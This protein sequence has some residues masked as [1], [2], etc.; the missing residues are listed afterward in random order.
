MAKWIILIGAV[1]ALGLLSLDA[2]AVTPVAPMADG[3]AVKV[4]G[5]VV[6][7]DGKNAGAGVD[8]RLVRLAGKTKTA[9]AGDDGKR[10]AVATTTTNAK[11]EFVFSGVKPGRYSVVA[12]KKGVG[13]GHVAVVVEHS[14]VKGVV[15]TLAKGKA[16]V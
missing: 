8:V 3:S 5:K 1:A 2:T 16:A 14:A 15:V 12:M 11:G 13:R 7:S 10:T 9:T 4:T 6:D